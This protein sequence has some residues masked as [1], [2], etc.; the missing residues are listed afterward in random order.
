MPV[1]QQLLLWDRLLA[2][3][4]LSLLAVAAAGLVLLHGATLLEVLPLPRGGERDGLVDIDAL[5]A[6]RGV[7]TKHADA[8]VIIPLCQVVLFA[9]TV[10]SK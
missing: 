10:Q 2:G 9:H 5:D 1:T 4:S 7:F 8:V 6:A 3:N